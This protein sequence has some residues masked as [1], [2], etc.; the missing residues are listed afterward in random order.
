VIAMDHTHAFT[1]GRTLTRAIKNIDRLQDERL[2]GHFPEFAEYVTHAALR[3]YTARLRSLSPA[4]ADGF[5]AGVPG[6]W[7]PP[8]DVVD[9]LREFL[10]QRA[11]FVGQ[12][13]RQMLV[14]QRYLDPELELGGDDQ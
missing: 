3:R 6:P 4:V 9:A 11:A 1:C 8:G 7:C 5:L 13:V 10:A 14:E 12:K 2:Y